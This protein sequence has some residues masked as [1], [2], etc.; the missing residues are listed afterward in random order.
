MKKIFL[1]IV[2]II[3][4]LIICVWLPIIFNPFV[5]KYK[6]EEYSSQLCPICFYAMQERWNIDTRTGKLE[7]FYQCMNCGYE[8]KL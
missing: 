3:I 5:E 6:T 2:S 4:I 1:L 8:I 7:H